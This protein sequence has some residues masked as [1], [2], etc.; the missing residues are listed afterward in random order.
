MRGQKSFLGKN[1]SSYSKINHKIYHIDGGQFVDDVIKI[2]IETILNYD[3]Q[4]SVHSLRSI[5]AA[6]G[7]PSYIVDRS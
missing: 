7:P 1:S 5:F 2:F 3:A 6:F 4:G